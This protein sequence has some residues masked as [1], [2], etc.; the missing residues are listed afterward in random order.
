MRD[1]LQAAAEAGVADLAADERRLR[2]E[3]REMAGTPIGEAMGPIPMFLLGSAVLFTV[4]IACTNIATLLMAQWTTRQHEIAIRA[5]IGASRG[6]IVRTL[7]AESF[8]I[9]V[10][11]GALGLGVT[12]ALRGLI[13]WNGGEFTAFNLTIRPYVFV[14]VAAMTMLAGLTTGLLPALGETS[15]AARH[16][17]TRLRASDRARQRWRHALV[18]FEIAVTVALLVTVGTLIS[19]TQRTFNADLGFDLRPLAIVHLQNGKGIDVAQAVSRLSAMPGVAR[20]STASAVPFGPPGAQRSVAAD[21]AGSQ[22][23]TAERVFVGTDF[24]DTLGVPIKA[25]RD[26]HPDERNADSR[27]VLVSEVL[28]SRLWPGLDA[29]GRDVWIDGRACTVV[30]IVGPYSGRQ[31]R[32]PKP[33]FFLPQVVE[34]QTEVTLLIRVA[35][36]PGPLLETVRREIQSLA[37]GHLVTSAIGMQQIVE[38][39]GSEIL[40]TVIPLA[41]LIGIAMLLSAAGV[42]GVLAF[43]V[44]HRGQE[45]AVRVAIGATRAEIA[46]LVAVHSLRVVAAGLAAGIGATF[47]LTRLAQGSGGIFDSPGWPAFVV[48]MLIVIIVGLVATWIPARRAMR[49]DPVHLLRAT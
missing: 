30:G 27:T 16:P 40:V 39:G 49:I 21:S 38:I 15:D 18:A 22:A 14:S 41:P 19:A 37:P 31:L 43:A 10:A 7:V 33:M 2:I 34:P 29:I 4:L 20:V 11:G 5:S 3:I 42:Y 44:A 45:L 35:G 24:F 46:R 17:V 32:P 25:G 1:R 26:F 8:L 47:G 23:L 6:R 36:Q 48:P 12:L 9:A 28:A 13:V